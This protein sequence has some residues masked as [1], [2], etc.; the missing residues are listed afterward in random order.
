MTCMHVVV[1]VSMVKDG[2]GD[3]TPPSLHWR[4]SPSY[5]QLQEMVFSSSPTSSLSRPNP[6][7]SQTL[8]LSGSDVF[9]DDQRYCKLLLIL[10]LY[11]GRE[12]V[13]DGTKPTI[14]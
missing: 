9:R 5:E 8:S 4:H 14:N 7:R 1:E 11:C 6:R 3:G 10:Q 13:S 2:S 12:D